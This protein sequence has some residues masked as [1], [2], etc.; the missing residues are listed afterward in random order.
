MAIITS[1]YNDRPRNDRLD[2][3]RP[4]NARPNTSCMCTS[5]IVPVFHR[6]RIIG[7]GFSPRWGYITAHTARL[8]NTR[9]ITHVHHECT[10]FIRS[11]IL[12]SLVLQGGLRSP[13]NTSLITHDH[14]L[15]A[16][17][18]HCYWSVFTA[19]SMLLVEC[20][21]QYGKNY[22]AVFIMKDKLFPKSQCWQSGKPNY[23]DGDELYL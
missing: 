13:W 9:P 1:V 23:N 22:K 6:L 8:N 2:N 17:C 7:L 3:W 10:S 12:G 21:W 4:K 16:D 18:I 5:I 19:E 20:L 14:L 11:V 15:L